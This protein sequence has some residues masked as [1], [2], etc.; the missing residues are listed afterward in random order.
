M[1]EILHQT[2][3]VR[4]TKRELVTHFLTKINYRIGLN[5]A[6]CSVSNANYFMS[7]TDNK[8]NY[9]NASKQS[10]SFKYFPT[11]IS[12]IS[13][14]INHHFG[15]YYQTRSS[16]SKEY[17]LTDLNLGIRYKHLL[18]SN[19][20]NWI[21]NYNIKYSRYKFL[22]SYGSINNDREIQ[23]GKKNFDAKKIETYSGKLYSGINPGIT[24]MR[25]M[26]RLF[27][28]YLESSYFIRMEE[29]DIAK[30]TEG[31]GFF[32]G[33]KTQTLSLNN[34]RITLL[35]NSFP[36]GENS[37]KEVL[38]VNISLGLSFDF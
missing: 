29:K 35:K 25:K 26:G 5:I 22:L 4:L 17:K 32:L 2:N 37:I 30:F 21:L 15:V 14:S 31:S 13:Y 38:P 11:L 28:L 23:I 9:I 12:E 24:I 7:Y 3:T 8:L 16:L 10:S 1:N 33:R 27:S 20:T 19:N 18:F 34:S 6:T 36:V